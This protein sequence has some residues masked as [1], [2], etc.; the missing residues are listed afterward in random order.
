MK[1]L[2]PKCGLNLALA[3]AR[4]NCRPALARSRP[5]AE[6][7][8]TASPQ[9]PAA[10]SNSQASSNTNVRASSNKPASRS[11]RWRAAHPDQYRAIMREYMRR[12]RKEAL[13]KAKAA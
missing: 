11:A 1:D 6:A 2:C 9:E 7:V 5:I 8:P 13:V 3:G 4:H 12:R 10:S